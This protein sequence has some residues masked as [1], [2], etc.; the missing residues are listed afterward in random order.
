MV[1]SNGD[2]R[3]DGRRNVRLDKAA[4]Y[5]GHSSYNM[6]L[7]TEGAFRISVYRDGAAWTGHL[8]LEIGVM[9]DHIKAS[10]RGTPSS[11]WQL[12]QSGTISKVKPSLRKLFGEPKTTSNVI[13][14]VQ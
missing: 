8:K 13:E 7:C 6:L 3:L 12:L 10:K 11:A 1:L 14:P 2:R 9:W 4:L 5:F